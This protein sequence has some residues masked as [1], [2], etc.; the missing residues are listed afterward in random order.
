[1]RDN[2]AYGREDATD[3]EVEA[4]A[5]S[6]HVTGLSADFL[7]DIRPRLSE[8]GGNLSQGQRQLLTIARAMLLNP[9]M[10]I[11]DEATS[12]VDVLTEL[13]IQRA[14]RKMMSGKTTFIIAH[15][16]STIRDADRILVL[17]QGNVVEQGTHEELLERN[18]FYSRL[19]HSQFEK[20]LS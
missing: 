7:R 5:R 13:K 6:A 3:E 14:F 18:G 12:S 1:M 2:I 20:S 15:R 8:D 19:Y 11:L 9:P 10:L 4:A 16:L 17:D